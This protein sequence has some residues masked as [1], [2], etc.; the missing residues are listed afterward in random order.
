MP[1]SDCSTGEQKALLVGLVLAQARVMS[2]ETGRVPLLLLDEVAA[3]LDGT[4]RAALIEV[5]ENLGAQAWITG[6]DPAVFQQIAFTGTH[7]T[8]D[9]QLIKNA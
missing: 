5:I 2:G 3:H 8:F 9:G 7:L 4:R 1:A 6:T